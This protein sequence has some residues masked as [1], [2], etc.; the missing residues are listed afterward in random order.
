MLLSLLT[1]LIQLGAGAMPS[2]SEEE[3]NHGPQIEVG[4]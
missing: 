1:L 3:L 2:D 4:G